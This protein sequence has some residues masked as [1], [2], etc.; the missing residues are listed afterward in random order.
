MDFSDVTTTFSLLF[1]L[2]GVVLLVMIPFVVKDTKFERTL[3][4]WM[5]FLGPILVFG[6]LIVF[7][8]FESALVSSLAE[9]IS[10]LL[11]AVM[12]AE[13]LFISV[14]ITVPFHM[15]GTLVDRGSSHAPQSA[16]TFGQIAHWVIGIGLLIYGIYA[17][18]MHVLHSKHDHADHEP[19]AET[20]VEA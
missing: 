17:L 2:I 14:F 16:L 3:F 9:V 6:F 15:I 13:F 11:L 8:S 10:L 1:F 20:Q 12:T 5:T 4:K 18:V 7:V 19:S